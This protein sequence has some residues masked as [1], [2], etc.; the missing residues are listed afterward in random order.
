MDPATM[1]AIAAAAN[2]LGGAISGGNQQQSHPRTTRIGQA[3]NYE[4]GGR[5]ALTAEQEQAMALLRQMQLA[6]ARDQAMYALMAR[7]GVNGPQNFVGRDFFGTNAPGAT[8]TSGGYNQAALNSQM[9]N[10]APGAG[11]FSN[12]SSMNLQQQMLGNLGFSPG[13]NDT[14]NYSGPTGFRAQPERGWSSGTWQYGGNVSN[15][16][17]PGATS[18]ASSTTPT[19]AATSD[20]GPTTLLQNKLTAAGGADAKSALARALYKKLNPGGS[21]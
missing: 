17:R 1:T 13:K 8:P 9:A 12:A 18:L 15:E 2:A 5:Q 6:P 14:W 16:S 20:F 4:I 11:G 19:T 7:M 3:F 21:R 10:Y